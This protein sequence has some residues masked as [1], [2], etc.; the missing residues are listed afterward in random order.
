[1][2]DAYLALNGVRANSGRLHVPFAGRWLVDLE[3]DGTAVPSGSAKVTIGTLS[4]VGTIVPQFSGLYA[5]LVRVRVV[6]GAGGWSRV[7]APR[8]YHDDGGVRRADVLGALARDVGETVDTAGDSTRLGIDFV[9]VA[10]A[11]ARALEGVL[12]ATPWRVDFDGVTRYGARAVAALARD[13]ELLEVE[14]RT[15]ILTFG[16]GD[17]GSVPIGA[18]VVDARLGAPL[19]VRELDVAIGPEGHRILAWGIA[20]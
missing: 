17:P 18:Q 8:S 12:G 1:M 6:A 20:A 2:T 5:S 11:G 3:L 15:K 16:A 10:E 13:A 4:L 9:R 14:P 7:V 19:V